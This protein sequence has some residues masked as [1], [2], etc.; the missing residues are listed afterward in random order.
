MEVD[1]FY[2]EEMEERRQLLK[3]KHDD[4]LQTFPEANMLYE[5]NACT[6]S[7]VYVVNSPDVRTISLW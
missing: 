1:E 4:V 7:G 3:L 6:A 2:E 5:M